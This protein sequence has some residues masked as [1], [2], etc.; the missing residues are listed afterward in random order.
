MISKCEFEY[1][2]RIGVEADRSYYIPFGEND[3]F[4]FTNGIVDRKTSSRFF[5]LDGEWAIKEYSDLD[6][7]DLNDELMDTIVVPS[8]LQMH[9]YD[10]IQ[11]L[12]YRYPFPFRPPY[13]PYKNPTYLYRKNFTVDDISWKYYLNFEGVDSCFYVYINGEY[14]GFGQISHATNEF[15]ITKYLKKGV[16]QLDVIVLKWCASSYLECQDK[17]RFTGI[18][19]SVYLLKRPQKHIVDYKIETILKGED[20][21]VLF[22]NESDVDIIVQINGDT[23]QIAANTRR[24]LYQRGIQAWTAETP[25]LYDIVISSCGEKILEQI[26][27]RN[28]EIDGKV[29]KINGQAIKLKGVNRHE[30]SPI[31]GATITVEEIVN[32]LEIMKSLNVNAIRTAHYMNMPEFYKLCDKM[33]FYV[34][35]ECDLETHGA[36]SYTGGYDFS[37]WKEFAEDQWI[38]EGIFQ[39]ERAL[40]ERDKNCTCVV[41]W[42]LGN[43][44]CFGLPFI[45]GANYIRERD[46]RPIHYEG[47]QVSDEKYYYSEY[48]DVV[49][50]MYPSIEWIR[51]KVLNNPNE[52]RPFVMCEYSH[53]MGNSNG[54]LLDYWNLIDSEQQCIGGFIWEWA[55]HAIKQDDKWLY[56]GDHGEDIHD[57]NFCVDGLLTPDRKCKP[58]TMELK[59][60]YGGKRLS[61]RKEVEYPAPI[62]KSNDV[63]IAVN[64]ENGELTSIRIEDQEVLASPLHINVM[65]YID[66]ERLNK[67]EYDMWA[68]STLTPHIVSFEKNAQGYNF[69]GFLA[70]NAM[71]PA[72]TYS[73]SYIISGAELKIEF[74]Y[75]IAEYIK[76]LPRVGLEFSVPNKF[77]DFAYIGYGPY[78]S[79]ID[80]FL[81]C[82]YGYYE[83]SAKENMTMY[84]RPQETGSHYASKYLKIKGLCE[85]FFSQESSFSV[86]PYTTKQLI[87]CKHSHELPNIDITNICIDAAMRGVGSHSCGPELAEKYE[88]PREGKMELT[89]VFESNSK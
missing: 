38:E 43:E 56:G 33:G 77:S 61:P 60:V 57:D 13:V 5:S 50:A 84:I 16:N 46:S 67:S 49:S 31:N 11:Y 78:E 44:S 15:D 10:K 9:G 81:S 86:L 24:E 48:V 40:V 73:I 26:G 74:A 53:A 6:S 28:I 51:D 83:S 27:F 45:K 42:S 21:I 79:Y 1:F 75:K 82:D 19:R 47:L 7:V 8:C 17:F 89:I 23:W 87:K 36:C 80:R 30:F 12:N 14:V 59:A 72:L 4:G 66:N 54:D 25:N 37:I 35:D 64:Q 32:D 63:K 62:K 76:H 22:E 58:N 55:D 34:M 18:F 65:R 69:I 71:K 41:M 3:K 52:T 85:M 29:F 39:R 68:L 20:G 88:V 70:N 2:D